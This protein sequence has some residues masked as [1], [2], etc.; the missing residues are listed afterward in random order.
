MLISLI[1]QHSPKSPSLSPEGAAHD[2]ESSESRRISASSSARKSF[3]EYDDTGSRSSSFDQNEPESRSNFEPST[4]S[5]DEVAAAQVHRRVEDGQDGQSCIDSKNTPQK[6]HLKKK[7]KE[8]LRAKDSAGSSFKT[9]RSSSSERKYS[10]EDF[11]N[12]ISKQNSVD[13]AEMSLPNDADVSCRSEAV[14]QKQSK[15]PDEDD[16]KAS[17]AIKKQLNGAENKPLHRKTIR[18]Q[19]TATIQPATVASPP[20][21]NSTVVEVKKEEKPKDVENEK[22]E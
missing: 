4:T 20:Q 2:D 13:D 5:G 1:P 9:K 18:P 21:K 15:A 16:N 22:V 12:R 7:R 10:P 8:K 6:K 17:S 11:S 19:S 3:T 14:G